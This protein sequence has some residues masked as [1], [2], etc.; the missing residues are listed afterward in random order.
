MTSDH[1]NSRI[2]LGISPPKQEREKAN[3]KIANLSRDVHD[4]KQGT[5]SSDV[6]GCSIVHGENMKRGF[7]FKAKIE[8][9]P[10]VR[11]SSAGSYLPL[12]YI[13]PKAKKYKIGCRLY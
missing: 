11:D 7:F 6:I 4:S 3:E 12:I 8:K 5:R 9:K 2:I 10:K 1:K 13:H